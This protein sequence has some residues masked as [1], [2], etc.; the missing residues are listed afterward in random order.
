M[1]NKVT[2]LFLI[3]ALSMPVFL[4]AKQVNQ[5]VFRFDTPWLGVMLADVSKKKLEGMGLKNGVK[6]SKVYNG[7]PADKAGL[8]MNDIIIT[9]DGEKVHSPKDL[10]NSVKM[11]KVNDKVDLEYFRDGKTNL[12]TVTIEK[13]K[14]PKVFMQK[15]PQVFKKKI[16]HSKNSVFLGVKVEELTDQLREF[17]NVS[18][19]LGVLIAEVVEDSP[20]EKAGLKAGDVI[21][22]IE[23]REIENYH[24]LIRGLNYFDPDDEV[25]VFFVRDKSNNSVEVKLAEPQDKFEKMKWFHGEDFMHDFDIDIEKFEDIDIDEEELEIKMDEMDKKIKI[26]KEIQIKDE[27]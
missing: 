3:I 7:S 26:K 5:E 12:I 11:K 14:P 18:D 8:E 2:Q 16:H 10:K 22:K 17:F 6:I 20:A 19:G 4:K 23:D 21:T 1:V 13:R 24:D 27:A 9:F 25:E 15:A